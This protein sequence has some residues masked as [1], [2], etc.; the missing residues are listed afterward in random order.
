VAVTQ[1]LEKGLTA[2]LIK[3]VDEPR[4][5]D[6]KI[7]PNLGPKPIVTPEYKGKPLYVKPPQ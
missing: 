5:I 3:S 1:I 2:Y 6:R 7:D 4:N